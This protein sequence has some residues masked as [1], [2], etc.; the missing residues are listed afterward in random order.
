V[1]VNTLEGTET[2]SI[3]PGTQPGSVV[4]V[5]GKGVPHLGRKGRGD[6]LVKINVQVP[7]RLGRRERPLI[8]E[9]AERRGERG[10]PIQGRLKPPTS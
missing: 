6:L 8:E 5:R 10:Q 7:E 4:A 9:F 3:P 2:I 1:E